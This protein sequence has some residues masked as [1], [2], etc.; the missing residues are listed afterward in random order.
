MAT[1]TEYTIRHIR[2]V[3]A[4]DHI[5]CL[6]NNDEEKW[7]VLGEFFQKG[8]ERKEKMVFVRERSTPEE[9]VKELEKGWI[10]EIQQCIENGQFTITHYS[11]VYL[12][13]G[14][15]EPNKMITTLATETEKAIHEGYP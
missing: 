9:I 12:A 3:C 5:C 11:E 7:Q 6:C 8:Y 10:P 4:G 1:N 2:D 15:F 13:N 14:G